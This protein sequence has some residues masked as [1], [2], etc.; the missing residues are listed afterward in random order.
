[1]MTRRW[2]WL[3][4]LAASCGLIP[5]DPIDF[6]TY[7][8]VD[9]P[10]AEAVDLVRTVTHDRFT[11]LFGGGFSMVWDGERG[12]LTA[13]P[14]EADQRRMTLH[15]TLLP[16]GADTD[17]EMLA[18]VEHMTRKDTGMFDWGDPKQDIHFEERLY[19]AFLAA[20]LDAALGP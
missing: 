12:N 6:R 5:P 3:V 18:L 14:I 16:R 17:V 2:C 7:P 8:L 1:M 13:G 20:Q 19:Q 15:V 11:A 4:L 10:Y 9:T